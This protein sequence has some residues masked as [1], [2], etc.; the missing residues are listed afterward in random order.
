MSEFHKIFD[1]N[2]PADP[3]QAHDAVA[4]Y[5]A[6][7]PLHRAISNLI[8]AVIDN[9]GRVDVYPTQA[10][11]E[12]AARLQFQGAVEFLRS[13]VELRPDPKLYAKRLEQKRKRTEWSRKRREKAAAR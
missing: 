12:E 5:V 8:D 3:S 10:E 9:A 2:A 11:Y 4:F 13:N 7:K 1:P 6:G